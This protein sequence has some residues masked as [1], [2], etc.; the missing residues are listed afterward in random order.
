[1]VEIVPIDTYGEAEWR[2]IC[3]IV[4]RFCFFVEGDLG[5][6]SGLGEGAE[7]GLGEDDCEANDD[8]DGAKAAIGRLELRILFIPQELSRAE[9]I[10]GSDHFLYLFKCLLQHLIQ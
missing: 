8:C 3:G 6:D 5:V 2:V 4:G 10:T 9:Q 7:D 1:M